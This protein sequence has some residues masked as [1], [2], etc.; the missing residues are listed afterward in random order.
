MEPT[1]P[2]DTSPKP[3][4]P[5][6]EGGVG[7]DFDFDVPADFASFE[8]GNDQNDDDEEEDEFD[9]S[10]E[11]SGEFADEK[12][13]AFEA[14]CGIVTGAAAPEE[15]YAQLDPADPT[16]VYFIFKWIKKYYHRDH[17][18]NAVVRSNLSAVTNQYRSLT[19]KAK[20]GENDP[21]VEWFE[22]TY[23]YREMS[24]GELIDVVVEKLE[25]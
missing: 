3:K 17:P 16:L 18:D 19:R 7:D 23:R 11:F 1:A 9:T 4:P 12:R 2:D 6:S 22:G 5:T 14:L 20:D 25:G 24:A 10:V 8:D 13:A 21:I 15:S